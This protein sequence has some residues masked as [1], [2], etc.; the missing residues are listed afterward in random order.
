MYVRTAPARG[1]RTLG[2]VNT[3]G[4]ASSGAATAATAIASATSVGSFA[5]PIGAGVG[6]LVG[7]LLAMN[8]P[9]GTCAPSA[10]DMAS[11]LKCW[12]HA[13]PDNYMPVWTN[14]WGGSDGKGWVY[15][16]GAKGG[17]PPPGGCQQVGQGG[18]NYC[19]PDGVSYKLPVGSGVRNTSGGPC[20]PP[21]TIQS[22]KGGGYDV[23]PQVSTT[24][25]ITGVPGIDQSIA[26][27][28]ADLSS[29][30]GPSVTSGTIAG[31]PTWLVLAGAALAAATLL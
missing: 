20:A 4:L 7:T 25:A 5:G 10:P 19:G 11:F 22:I 29:I 26:A 6:L 18:Q 27:A 2:A 14:M 31:I 12:K 30:L 3:K 17:Q 23:A 24:A 16:S 8:H 9:N 13:I 15:C 28:G 21:G 1:R